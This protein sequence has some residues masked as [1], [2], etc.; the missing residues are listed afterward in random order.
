MTRA[1]DELVFMG[2]STQFL[3]ELG[4][5]DQ[6]APDA[7]D[8]DELE[9]V[10]NEAVE[11]SRTCRQRMERGFHEFRARYQKLRTYQDMADMERLGD[12]PTGEIV[13]NLSGFAQ[14]HREKDRGTW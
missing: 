8:V 7:P 1:K 6:L 13:E 14:V 3:P 5:P 9:T 12:V 2:K 4:L 11:A 10:E